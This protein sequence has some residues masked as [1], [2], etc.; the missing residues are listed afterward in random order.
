MKKYTFLSIPFIFACFLIVLSSSCSK[1]ESKTKN[2]SIAITTDSVNRI[3]ATTAFCGGEF[4]TEG[5]PEIETKG[6]CWGLDTL[7]TTLNG[8]TVN[9]S[10][11]VN[12]KS[13]MTGLI[14]DT[15]YHVRAYVIKSNRET[16]YGAD[17]KF[18]T[19]ISD[20]AI[21]TPG[22]NSI[23]FSSQTIQFTVTAGTGGLIYGHYG[24]VGNGLNCDLRIEFP[25]APITGR[26]VTDKTLSGTIDNGKCIVNGPF[27]GIYAQFCVAAPGDTVYVIKTGEGKYSMTFCSLLFASTSSST[28]FTANGN[29]T[30][31]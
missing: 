27:G 26:Y 13:L 12:Y 22:K 29:L 14:P 6:V 5:E 2:S 19:M 31:E 1:D 10:D 30:T 25:A 24:L 21:C 7:P 23:N 17:L 16:I 3:S 4:T 20:S 11:V 28:S 9:G 15:V 18:R 8:T